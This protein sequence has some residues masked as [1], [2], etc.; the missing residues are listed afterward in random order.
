ML[1]QAPG[2]RSHPRGTPADNGWKVQAERATDTEGA[3]R[4][5]ED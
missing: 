1:T 3:L 4:V 2:K 5:P